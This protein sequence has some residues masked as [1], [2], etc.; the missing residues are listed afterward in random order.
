MTFESAPRAELLPARELLGGDEPARLALARLLKRMLALDALEAVH[1]AVPEPEHAPGYFANA[2]ATLGVQ[3]DHDPAQWQ[4][5][6]EHGPCVIVANHPFGM[7]E[8]IAMGALLATRRADFCFLG[9]FLLDRIPGIR[10]FNIAVDPFGARDSRR[11]N[12]APLREAMQWLKGGGALVLFPAGEVAHLHWNGRIAE[13]CWQPNLARLIRRSGAPIVPVWFAGRNGAAFHAL[14][15]AHPLLRTARLPRELLAQRGRTLRIEAG[16]PIAPAQ[17]PAHV[18]D[19]MFMAEL[20]ALTLAL[21][22]TSATCATC[23]TRAATRTTTLAPAVA[24]QA[25]RVAL[26]PIEAQRPLDAMLAEIAALPDACKLAHA[27]GLAVYCTRAER[28]PNVLHEIGR[29]REITFREAGEGTGLALDL[30]AFDAYYEHLFLWDHERNELAGAYRMGRVDEIVAAHGV[31]GLYTHTL[32]RFDATLLARI[33]PA[34]EMGRSFVRSEYQRSFG[35]LYLLWRGIG[36]FVAREPKYRWL[37]GAVSISDEYCTQSKRLMTAFIAHNHL[38][39]S[40]ASLVEPRHPFALEPGAPETEV[41][42]D[43]EAL[44]ERVLALECGQRDIPVL[45]KQYL[46]LGACV[47]GINRDPRFQDVLDGLILVD[48]LRAPQRLTEKYLGREGL[49]AVHAYHASAEHP[50]A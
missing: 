25:P 45:L 24:Q 33:G 41:L 37:F 29:Q 40:L 22:D 3:L 36:A 2:L 19:A 32:F 4:R 39:G 34:L 23:A 27:S 50:E 15:L 30:D 8:G 11:R 46:K 12:F 1:Q 17:L 10:P 35:P 5:V 16:E 26:A 48:L 14:G 6:P 43:L 18:D 44:S 28:I 49:A 42:D 20:R 31:Q 21:S 13:S 9:N 47:L 7:V 38:D